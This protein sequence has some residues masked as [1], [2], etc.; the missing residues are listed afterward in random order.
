MN[1]KTEDFFTFADT[2]EDFKPEY[3]PLKCWSVLQFFKLIGRRTVLVKDNIEPIPNLHY[4][5]FSPHEERY[6]LKSYRNYSLNQLYFYRKDLDFSGE[7]TAIESLKRYID[8]ENVHILLTNEQVEET[9]SM[10]Q[11]LWKSQFN[12]EGKLNYRTYIQLLDETLKLNDYKEYCSGLTGF[13]TV[14]NQMEIHINEL[15]QKAYKN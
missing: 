7:D 5:V 14:C 10:L 4:C 8:D 3:T 6:Y 13:K 1:L 12:V 15:W 11:R 9:R 2:L